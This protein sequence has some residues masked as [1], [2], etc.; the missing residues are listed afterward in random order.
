MKYETKK[1]LVQTVKSVLVDYSGSNFKSTAVQNR[2]AQ[3]IVREVIGIINEESSEDFIDSWMG[4]A[5]PE[6]LAKLADQNCN[7]C[8]GSGIITQNPAPE[9]PGNYTESA[10]CDCLDFDKVLEMDRRK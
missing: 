5:E 3:D 9:L 7:G 8:K 10:I 1:Q 6:Q 2:V 4:S